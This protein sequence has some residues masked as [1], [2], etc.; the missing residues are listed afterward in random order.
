MPLS[1]LSYTSILGIAST[2]FI[3]AV[4]LIDGLSKREAPGSLWDP[5]PTSLL[6]G[7]LG[8]LGISFGLFMAGFSG[9]AVIPSLA[10]D[11][12]DPTQFDEMI[13]WAF[14]SANIA[15]FGSR[16]TLERASRL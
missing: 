12:I 2:L 5:A 15:S 3:V 1:L 16:L 14:V 9:H 10:K 6:P 7:H 13:N 8:E 11:M 4:I